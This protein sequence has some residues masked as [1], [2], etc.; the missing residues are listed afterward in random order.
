MDSSHRRPGAIR[1]VRPVS[2]ALLLVPLT[3][4]G[5]VSGFSYGMGAAIAVAAVALGAGLRATG[6]RSLSPYA[7]V[8]VLLALAAFAV[9]APVG[10]GF[11]FLAGLSALA[12]L[13]WLVDDPA[14]PQ[15][16]ALR[17]LPTVAV[18]ALA[19]AI[20]WSSALFL[21]AG[22]VPLGVAGGLLALTLAL[23]AF[24]VGRPTLFDREEA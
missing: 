18:P 20:A 5:Y 15:R 22:A 1:S 6:R 23:V 2:L 21:P 7:P 19:L 11:E 9:H 24:L 14:R 13:V 3:T 8:P 16:G 17:S 4:F 12:F 10:L